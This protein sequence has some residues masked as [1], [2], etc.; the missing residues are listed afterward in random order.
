[1]GGYGVALAKGTVGNVFAVEHVLEVDG[2]DAHVALADGFF[3]GGGRG[4]GRDDSA[5]G[6]LQLVA[7]QGGAGVEDQG[8]LRHGVQGDGLALGVGV[9]VASSHGDDGGREVGLEVDRDAVQPVLGAGHHDLSQVGVV[10]QQGKEGLCFGVASSDV[11]LQHLG[12]VLGHHESG[13]QDANH[14]EA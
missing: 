10:A 8:G 12:P 13:E 6:G 11:V 7:G 3:E 9:G 4:C 1:M 5:A 14:G 2:G